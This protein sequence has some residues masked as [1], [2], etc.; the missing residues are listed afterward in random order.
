M[1][2]RNPRRGAPQ[3]EALVGA[4]AP[5]S[6]SLAEEAHHVARHGLTLIVLRGLTIAAKFALTLFVARYLGLAPL[7]RYGLIASAAVL[8]PV[9][10]GF[11][12]SNNLGRE[13]V[14]RGPAGVTLQLLQYFLYL[15]PAYAVVS[16]VMALIF[17]IGLV[18]AGVFG[19]LLFLEHVGLDMFALMTVAGAL[20][21][22]NLVFSIR[23]AGWTLVYMP[24]ALLDPRLRSL[25]AI[26]W[27]W[28][29]GN[30]VATLLAVLVTPGWG[31]LQ[32]ARAL[33]K[34]R[35]TLPHRHGSTPLYFNDV[36]NTGFVYL[37]RYIIGVFLS[38]EMLGIYTLYWS[39]VNA[40]SNLVTN[41]AVQPRKATLLRAAGEIS[42]FNRSLRNVALTSGQLGLFLSVA[43]IVALYLAIPYIKRPELNAYL[44]VLFILCA[45]MVLRTFY[46][47]I[48]LSF[49]AYRRDDL[50]LYSGVVIL[51]A[52]L[53]LNVV[54]VPMLGIWGASGVLVV[55]YGIGVATRALIV[56]RGFRPGAPAVE[57]A[58]GTP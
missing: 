58:V 9:L 17:P 45:S 22:A 36:A 53:A 55:S 44:P 31:W 38:A 43:A 13:A 56:S 42:E 52:S 34:S 49:Y 11:G 50:M 29:A 40:T 1:L 16:A 5:T 25:D 30:V 47:V 57:G 8:S 24:L 27:F 39:V 20:Y 37:D 3:G 15:V 10:L 23:T 21:G 41:T 6:L 32:A 54:L 26:L 51:A 33:P 12:V 14:R 48:G 46:E 4:P 2:A 19:G 28:L 7:G 35:L 18:Q